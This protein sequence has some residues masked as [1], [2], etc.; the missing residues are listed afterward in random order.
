MKQK[1]HSGAKKTIKQ[2][3]TGMRVNKA[4]KRHLLTNKSKRQKNITEMA[5]H[6]TRVRAIRRML[7]GVKAA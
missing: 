5:V 4:A 1:T 7:S 2:T 3:K 6:P